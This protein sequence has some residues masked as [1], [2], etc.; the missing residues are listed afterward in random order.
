MV[1]GSFP[2]KRKKVAK[3][4]DQLRIGRRGSSCFPFGVVD[5]CFEL[6]SFWWNEGQ[7]R[8][9]SKILSISSIKDEE[10]TNH[11]REESSA[12]VEVVEI[13]PWMVF[14]EKPGRSSSDAYSKMATWEIRGT[15]LN[16][17]CLGGERNDVWEC[18]N[19]GVSAQNRHVLN[20]PFIRQCSKWWKAFTDAFRPREGERKEGVYNVTLLNFVGKTSKN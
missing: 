19:L 5:L 3:P 2:V 15:G 9:Q 14:K 11:F 18:Y 6:C 12:S 7:C 8:I 17:S 10:E 20:D 1:P 16:V 4:I 13:T